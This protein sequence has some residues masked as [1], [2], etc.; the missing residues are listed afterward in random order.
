MLEFLGIFILLGILV[1]ILAFIQEHIFLIIGVIIGF[2]S[3]CVFIRFRLSKDIAKKADARKQLPMQE[4]LALDFNDI[5]IGMS[6]SIV[7]EYLGTNYVITYQNETEKTCRWEYA[8]IA[9]S[10]L[11][12]SIT[13]RFEKDKTL[14]EN[15]I[16]KSKRQTG[17]WIN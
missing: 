7:T 16:V 12:Y 2:I 15:Y 14:F 6:D 10:N 1:A 13:I 11:V 3:L 17:I 4:K 5:G 9:N 8:D